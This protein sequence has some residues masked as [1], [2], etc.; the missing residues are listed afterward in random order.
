MSKS[1]IFVQCV[2]SNMDPL[3]RTVFVNVDAIVSITKD[4]LGPNRIE[5]C[6][7]RVAA[8][9]EYYFFMDKSE[10]LID[11]IVNRVQCII[12]PRNTQQS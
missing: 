1:A 2:E 7:I 8:A 3:A 11:S 5:G 6:V 12:T 9:R 10:Y 4:L